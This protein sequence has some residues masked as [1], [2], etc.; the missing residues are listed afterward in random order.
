MY[1][2]KILVYLYFLCYFFLC[3][4]AGTMLN[5]DCKYLFFRELASLHYNWYFW[6]LGK[7]KTWRCLNWTHDQSFQ[8]GWS[9]VVGA[10]LVFGDMWNKYGRWVIH[11][12]LNDYRWRIWSVLL[13]NS[14][15]SIVAK[16]DECSFIIEDNFS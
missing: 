3:L 10:G 13:F 11:E 7:E 14:L 2:D 8:I 9:F 1:K 6:S 15:W 5:T 4:Q 16:Q 12:A